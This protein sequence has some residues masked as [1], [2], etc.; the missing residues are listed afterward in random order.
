M[1]SFCLNEFAICNYHMT[2]FYSYSSFSDCLFCLFAEGGGLNHSVLEEADDIALSRVGIPIHHVQGPFVIF[3]AA[4]GDLQ[5]ASNGGR[6][7][8]VTL[9]P[10]PGLKVLFLQWDSTRRH[11]SQVLDLSEELQGVGRIRVMKEVPK[12]IVWHPSN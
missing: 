7:I 5:Q 12:S 3:L 9:V 10:V 6:H 4:D 8:G 2:H 11:Q 1:L